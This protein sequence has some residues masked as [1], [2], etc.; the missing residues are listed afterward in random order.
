M[1]QDEFLKLIQEEW[2]FSYT[3]SCTCSGQRTI[4]YSKNHFTISIRVKSDKASLKKY[5]STI[6]SFK[7]YY[8]FLEAISQ[9]KES[10]F[11]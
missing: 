5:G 9:E 8:E 4:K 7:P 2:G 11:A 10:N 1:T 6:K 3:G